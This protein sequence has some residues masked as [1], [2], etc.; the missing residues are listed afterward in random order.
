MSRNLIT[1]SNTPKSQPSSSISSFT[2]ADRS[3]VKLL[4]MWASPYAL[5]TRVALNVKSVDYEFVDENLG[6][7]SDLLLKS[8]PVHKKVPVLIHGEKIVCE[9]LIIVQYIDETW[10]SAGPDSILPA[11]PYERSVVRF[12]AAYLD[13]KCTP[14]LKEIQGG[15]AKKA[16]A[17]KLTDSLVLFEHVFEKSSAGKTFFGG[18]H[19]GYLD[20]ALG[21]FLPWIKA[22]EIMKNVKIFDEAKIPRLVEWA[23]AFCADEAVRDVMPETSKLVEFAKVLFARMKAAAAQ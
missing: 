5:R 7:K 18:D 6:A 12:W 19:I 15:E 1:T 20:I 2:M 23:D 21:G 8:N 10:P 17:E 11:D 4:G 9:S 3:G 13:D 16:A 14:L 22:F